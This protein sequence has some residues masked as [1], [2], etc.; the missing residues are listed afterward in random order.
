MQQSLSQRV[1]YLDELAADSGRP[2]DAVFPDA[3]PQF[4][5]SLY[6]SVTELSW[7]TDCDMVTGN[8]RTKTD[9]TV[10]AL[11]PGYNLVSQAA[12]A[13]VNGLTVPGVVTLVPQ[14]QPYEVT[15]YWRR[16]S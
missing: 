5:S 4:P 7:V 1:R 3:K 15:V 16:S 12:S 6:F 11:P 13:A 2:V 10:S 14:A 8:C 9:P